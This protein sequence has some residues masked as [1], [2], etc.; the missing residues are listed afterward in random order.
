[1]RLSAQAQ[2]Q[3]VWPRLRRNFSVGLLG[4]GLSLAIKLV[5]TA[6][7][8]WALR[9]DDL[10]RVFIVI[11]L[12]VFLEAFV[13]LRVSDVMFRFFQPFKE[14]KDALALQGLLLL[15]LGL[16]LATG[17]LIG[18]GVFLLSP[19]LAERFYDSPELV[20]LFYI[21]GCTVLVSAFREVYEPILRM[22]DRFPSVV[23]PQVLG[24]LT[25]T[26]IL[27]AYFAGTN[28]HDLRAVVAAFTVGA[29]VQH[30]PPLVLALR[31][32]KPSLSGIQARRA[33]RALNK[34]RPEMLRCLFHSNLSGY[35]KFATDPGD[36]FLLGIFSTPAQVALYGLAR[37]L[38][39][40]LAL[41]Q[42]NVQTAFAPEVFSL[43][44]KGKFAQLKRLV[45]RYVVS[46]SVLG[47]LSLAGGLLLGRAFILWLSRPEYLA[48]LPVFYALV[49]V[50]SLMLV[51]AVFRPLSV[52][53]DLM[54]WYNLG[55][56]FSAAVVFVFA[57]AG[58][59]DATGMAYAQLAGALVLRLVCNV[60]VWVRLNALIMNARGRDEAMARGAWSE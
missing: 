27:A 17:M 11:N 30:L 33:A 58:K 5:Q 54:K 43:I 29:L 44:A 20:P 18:V 39:A 22:H 25:T 34:Y 55:L 21:Y 32:L 3:P 15:C 47:C 60:P 13:G 35:L 19:W 45:S 56:L 51:A 14:R 38:T 4:S 48:A 52:G 7:L 57:A 12:F 2:D 53:L 37:Q 40:P 6:L 59:L 36:V 31:L 28:A 42:T 41:L 10:G 26:T 23:V 50:A 9:I 1:V 46:A 16:S 24:G 49:V 8:T